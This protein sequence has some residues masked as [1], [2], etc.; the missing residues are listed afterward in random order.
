[1][2]QIEKY[3]K[4]YKNF[5]RIGIGRY[6]NIYKAQNKNSGKYVAIKEIDKSRFKMLV[7]EK[8][9]TEI[10]NIMNNEYIVKLTAKINT[11]NYFYIIMDLCIINLYDYIK[12]RENYVTIKE[13]K[14]MLNQLN[15]I[16]K[17]MN[18][19][20]IIHGDLKPTNILISLDKLDKCSF[21]LSDFNS[22]QF[23]NNATTYI[24]VPSMTVPPE[25]LNGENYNFKS[26]IWSLGIIIYFM[27]NKEYP[28]NGL[29]E[30]LLFKDI[31]S[32]KR[33]KLSN[34]DKLNDLIN[35]MLKIN[36]NER[37]SWDEYFNHPFFNQNNFDKFKFNCDEHSKL[38]NHYCKE[39]KKNICNN[40]LNEHSTHTIITFNK[41]GLNDNEIKRIENIFIDID[42]KLNKFKKMKNDIE[43]LLLKMKS[44][45]ENKLIYEN[46]IDNN[47]KEYYIKYLENINKILDNNEIKLI[48]LTP[49]ENEIICIYDIIKNK[50]IKDD[51]LINPI[52]ILNCFEEAKK[53]HPKWEGINNENEIKKN[54]VL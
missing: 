43:K 11:R 16:F 3:C 17:I 1:M 19:K 40:C 33:L 7:N 35:K 27:L 46:D 23:N 8:Y 51:Y 32:G 22:S 48:D 31:N 5:E 52:R 44:I 4:N 34:D 15:N 49:P 37:I 21:K 9:D 28:Y 50:D 13:I 14:E 39:C 47:Y 45:K 18:N 2:S 54:C 20:K 38:I 12:N 41:I 29:N 6:S 36:Y 10:K 26:D 53:D 42:N 25:I 24:G 30:L